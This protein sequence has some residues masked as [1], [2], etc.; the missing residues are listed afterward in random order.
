MQQSIFNVTLVVREYDEALAF[1]V[2]KLGFTLT[3]DT[4]RPDQDERWV[5]DAARRSTG[6]G[7][8]LARASNDRQLA[9]VGNQTGGRVAFFLGTDDIAR[10]HRAMK[11]AGIKFVREPTAAP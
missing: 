7:V 4:Y 3:E 5:I 8:L 1:F 6:T 2:G 9:A 10:D 11:A